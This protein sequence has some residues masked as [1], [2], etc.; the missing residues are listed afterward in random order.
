MLHKYEYAIQFGNGTYYSG[1]AG[2]AYQTRIPMDVYTYTE[3]GAYTKIAQMGW[4][5]TVIHYH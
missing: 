1:R 5:A 2:E 4:D 3:Y